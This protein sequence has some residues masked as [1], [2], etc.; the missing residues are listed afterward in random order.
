MKNC[1]KLFV[2]IAALLVAAVLFGCETN[3]SK[4][5]TYAVDNGD[6]VK[7]SLN[8]KDG[9]DLS[10]GDP[11]VVSCNGEVLSQGT[12]M[13]GEAYEQFAD[14]VQNDE[15]AQLLDSG[16]KD[17][18]SYIFWNFNGA[19]FNYAILIDGTNTAI[20]LGN[21]V[22]E[23]CAKECFERLTFTAEN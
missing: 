1:K 4:S 19:E 5:Y 7:I 16:V 20:V 17:G 3:V 6:S 9:Y 13:Q 15:N 21:D 2:C 11:F 18:N 10:S 12:F 14:A 8:T 22:S 23:E